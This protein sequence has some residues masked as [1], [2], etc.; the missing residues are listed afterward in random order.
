[1]AAPY[2]T[3]GGA[4]ALHLAARS[5]RQD[6]AY[7]LV[8]IVLLGNPLPTFKNPLRV[9][10]ELATIDCISRG[11]LVPG[12]IRGA[13]MFADAGVSLQTVT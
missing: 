1:M 12:F 3:E 10:E 2:L 9:A 4:D 11:R 6:V 7:R 5:V 13:G 8:R